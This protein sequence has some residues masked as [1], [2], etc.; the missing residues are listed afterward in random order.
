[1]VIKLNSLDELKEAVGGAEGY[2][3]GVTLLK[4]GELSHHFFS[5]KF[6]FMDMLKSHNKV[7]DL[8]IRTLEED[9]RVV[10]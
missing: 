2:M 1:M 3:V 5:D 7:K 9:P 6:P 4:D 10:V 8:I